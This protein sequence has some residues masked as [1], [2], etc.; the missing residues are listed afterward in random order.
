MGHFNKS[1]DLSVRYTAICIKVSFIEFNWILSF[2]FNHPYIQEG[3]II[4][5]QV[6]KWA[7]EAFMGLRG[8]IEFKLYSLFVQESKHDLYLDPEFWVTVSVQE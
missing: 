7:V 5:T 6:I 3:T 4:L 8:E 1:L 2:N